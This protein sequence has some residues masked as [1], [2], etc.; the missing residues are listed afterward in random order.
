MNDHYVRKADRP[1]P[2]ILGLTASPIMRS[3]VN[4][5]HLKLFFP[6][7]QTCETDCFQDL[8]VQPRC[9]MSHTTHSAQRAPL[10]RTPT[11]FCHTELFERRQL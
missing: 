11:P 9:R 4:I 5:A 2:R 1:R 8:G 3:N 10:S 7:A 6:H